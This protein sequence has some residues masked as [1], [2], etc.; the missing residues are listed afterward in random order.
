MKRFF[1]VLLA[2]VALYVYGQTQ[3]E[4]YL[5]YIE[6]Y[7][8]A[9]LKQEREYKIPACIT[10]AQGLLESGAG[11]SELARE[12]NNHFGIKC[13]KD[14]T[15]DTY[16]HDDETRNECFR[17][18]K[19]VEE[20]YEDHSKFLLRPRYASL[21]ELDITDYKGWAHGLKQCGYA[22]DPGYATKLITI[23]EDYDLASISSSEKSEKSSKREHKKEQKEE[24]KAEPSA[25]PQDTVISSGTYLDEFFGKADTDKKTKPVKTA[26][27]KPAK[28]S[29]GKSAKPK[30][31]E[32][33]AVSEDSTVEDV[34]AAAMS[35]D[36]KV[37]SNM[38][39]VSL[40]VYHAVYR[41]GLVR[42]VTAAKGDTYELIADEF[43]IELK[44]LLKYNNAKQGQKPVPGQS[45]YL[46][47]HK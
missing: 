27:E 14:W 45:V 21:F 31:A 25:L 3:N 10:L 18:Y 35:T 23:I 38:G 13:H 43:N 16:T 42:W 17:K 1:T 7:R 6:K 22:T 4:A 20:S 39:T 32:I 36:K 28:Q 12:A 29:G 5:K 19:K 15:G 24:P 47:R 2:L 9:A 8:E 46:T 11:N 37:T 30:A 33:A 41:D 44:R 40:F 34:V 26:H